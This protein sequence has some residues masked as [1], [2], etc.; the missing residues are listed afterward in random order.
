MRCAYKFIL[1]PLAVVVVCYFAIAEIYHQIQLTKFLD[2]ATAADYAVC[3]G[4]YEQQVKLSPEIKM[5]LLNALRNRTRV[6]LADKKSVFYG[7]IQLKRNDDVEVLKISVM[8]YPYFYFNDV[9]V[10]VDA[11][12][13]GKLGIT[14]RG[15]LEESKQR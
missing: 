2:L 13:V 9:P 4:K 7:N 12:I 5:G 1:M 3:N 10:K 8:S 14:F 6:L 11:N 15:Y